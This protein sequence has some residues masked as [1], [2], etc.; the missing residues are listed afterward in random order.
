MAAYLRAL[1][2]RFELQQKLKAKA[3]IYDA[4]KESMR[5]HATACG[6]AQLAFRAAERGALDC[7]FGETPC[8]EGRTTELTAAI[9]AVRVRADREHLEARMALSSLPSDERK[10]A[11]SE[12]ASS[13]CRAPWW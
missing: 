9:D 12:F 13:G 10:A 6:E 5:G 11:A 7:T 2:P 4:I 3:R 1:A 8:E